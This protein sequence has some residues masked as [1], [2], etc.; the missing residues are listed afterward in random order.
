[1]SAVPSPSPRAATRLP[2]RSEHPERGHTMSD[3]KEHWLET[4]S[5]EPIDTDAIA[6]DGGDEEP[7]DADGLV[8]PE[9]DEFDPMQDDSG[10]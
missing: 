7:Y 10:N 6:E 1:M 5:G 4:P 2:S 8:E 3:A 9:H